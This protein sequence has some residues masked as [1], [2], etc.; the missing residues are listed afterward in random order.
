MAVSRLLIDLAGAT[1]LGTTRD[2]MASRAFLGG[3]LEIVHT[4]VTRYGGTV[5]DVIG[6]AVTASWGAVGRQ[7]EDPERAV[8]A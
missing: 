2:P 3:Y 7:E 6:D 1:G 4:V 8:R 5:E